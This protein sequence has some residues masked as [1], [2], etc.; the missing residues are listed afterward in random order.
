MEVSSF[1]ILL[2]NVFKYYNTN[3]HHNIER[4]CDGNF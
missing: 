4:G 3:L 2:K 1:N